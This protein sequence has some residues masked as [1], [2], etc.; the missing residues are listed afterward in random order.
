MSSSRTAK[1]N[2]ECAHAKARIAL[3]LADKADLRARVARARA[4]GLACALARFKDQDGFDRRCL[5]LHRRDQCQTLPSIIEEDDESAVDGNVSPLLS[6]CEFDGDVQ[7]NHLARVFNR[8][9]GASACAECE[10]DLP[11]HKDVHEERS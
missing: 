7:W 4:D 8:T 9:G 2:Q 6:P 5:Q 1:G 3:L 10:R 11:S